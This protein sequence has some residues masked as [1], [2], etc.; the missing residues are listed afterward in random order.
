MRMSK[1]NTC[2]NSINNKNTDFIYNLYNNEH[3]N[4]TSFDKKYMVS[5][6]N[7]NNKDVEHLVITNY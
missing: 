2:K 3:F 1:K 6:M 7:R 4:I 5:F